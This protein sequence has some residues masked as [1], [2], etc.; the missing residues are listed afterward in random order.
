MSISNKENSISEEKFR[1]NSK[2]I[3]IEINGS[4]AQDTLKLIQFMNTYKNYG[5]LEGNP[6]LQINL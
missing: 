5:Y 3:V 1:F 6:Q 2:N 4:K